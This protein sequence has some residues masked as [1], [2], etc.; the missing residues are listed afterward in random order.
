[1]PFNIFA[2]IYSLNFYCPKS[3]NPAEFYIKTITSNPTLKTEQYKI[4]KI[5]DRPCD[6]SETIS[7]AMNLEAECNT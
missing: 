6:D 1:M 5:L 2:C 4:S 3:Y 7:E